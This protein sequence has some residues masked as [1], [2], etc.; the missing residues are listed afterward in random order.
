MSNDNT[1][2]LCP[3]CGKTVKLACMTPE[4]DKIEN[5]TLY[6]SSGSCEWEQNWDRTKTVMLKRERCTPE[7]TNCKVVKIK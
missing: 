5:I 1:E 7:N 3:R 2:A 4:Q 6:C